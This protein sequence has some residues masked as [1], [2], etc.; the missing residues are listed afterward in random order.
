MATSQPLSGVLTLS[1][2]VLRGRKHRGGSSQSRQSLRVC[3]VSQTRRPGPGGLCPGG[4][5]HS[6]DGRA[7]PSSAP[8]RPSVFPGLA[9]AEPASPRA[10]RGEGQSPRHVSWECGGRWCLVGLKKRGGDPERGG[11]SSVCRGAVQGV[12]GPLGPQA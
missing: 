2:R 5:P 4:R 10:G 9:Q 12:A 11:H 1:L 7:S 8:W 6:E 3:G